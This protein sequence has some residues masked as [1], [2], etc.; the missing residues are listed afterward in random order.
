MK[1]AGIFFVVLIMIM[2][3]IVSPTSIEAAKNTGVEESKT[4]PIE[5]VSIEFDQRTFDLDYPTVEKFDIIYFDDYMSV[6]GGAIADGELTYEAVESNVSEDPSAGIIK[7][8]PDGMSEVIRPGHVSVKISRLLAEGKQDEHDYI[9]I[10]FVVEGE[11]I[12]EINTDHARLQ[13]VPGESAVVNVSAQPS[14]LSDTA[15]YESISYLEEYDYEVF[16]CERIYYDN[17]TGEAV[18]FSA[19]DRS[20]IKGTFNYTWKGELLITGIEVGEGNLFIQDSTNSFES[21]VRVQVV[22]ETKTEPVVSPP[23]TP[24]STAPAQ[25]GSPITGLV[26]DATTF[27]ILVAL[28]AVSGV[29]LVNL[30][31][32][33]K[34]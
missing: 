6:D 20:N 33:K 29:V 16:V 7:V 25:T 2:G 34:N 4:A 13:L 22:E 11:A 15:V 27:F 30:Q 24:T 8:Y 17:I 3:V 32:K 5:G 31:K 18:H 28:A 10:S 12:H 19:E 1:R 26:N 23:E 9:L 14:L 21:M